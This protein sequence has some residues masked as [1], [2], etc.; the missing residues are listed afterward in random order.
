MKRFLLLVG[1]VIAVN[2]QADDVYRSI[3]SN[4]KVHYGDHPLSGAQ[5]VEALKTVKEPVPDE[6]LPYETQLAKQNHPVT[7]YVFPNCAQVCKQARDSLNKRG[8]PFA[9]KNLASQEDINAFRKTA[10]EGLLPALAVGKTI[11]N[12][13]LAEQW[14]KEL[15]FAGYPK[16][17]PYRAPKPATPATPK[18]E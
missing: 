15:D 9:E 17:A 1:L 7:L 11:L 13:F 2:A 8:I 12:G 4:G 16:N 18:S 5:D 14:D 3:D 6:T 10:G